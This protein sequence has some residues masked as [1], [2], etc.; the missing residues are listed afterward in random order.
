MTPEG[1]IKLEV[2]KILKKFGAHYIMPV[3]NGLGTPTLDFHCCF[4]GRYFAIE[5]K[6]PGNKPTPRQE[7]TLVKITRGPSYGKTFVIDGEEGLLELLDWLHSIEG[8]SIYYA[9]TTRT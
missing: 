1:K 4:F 2:K 8:A 9:C 5:T 3:Q 6:A 7:R